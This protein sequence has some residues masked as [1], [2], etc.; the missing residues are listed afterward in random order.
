MEASDV[1]LL[2]GFDSSD[3]LKDVL[4]VSPGAVAKV[5]G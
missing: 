1:S 2:T 3:D 4:T 5:F